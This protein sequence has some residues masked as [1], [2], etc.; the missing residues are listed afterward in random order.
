VKP[1]PL[2]HVNVTDPQAV[3]LRERVK[4]YTMQ[5]DSC[6]LLMGT[7]IAGVSLGATQASVTHKLKRVPQGWQVVGKDAESDVWESKV[8][9][10]GCLY[11]TASATVTVDLWVF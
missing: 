11:L 2:E 10:D 6:D 9:D 8:R 1:I 5:T 3:L 7:L 4:R